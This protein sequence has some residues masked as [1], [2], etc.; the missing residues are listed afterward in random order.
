VCLAGCSLLA[1][2]VGGILL[3]FSFSTVRPEQIA[4]SYNTVSKSIKSDRVY[5]AGRFHLGLGR[6]FITYPQTIQTI[7][8]S[9]EPDADST[10][11]GV[12][13]KDGQSIDISCSFM[14]QLIPEKT[15]AIYEK[16]GANVESEP[17]K[18]IYIQQ[19]QSVIKLTTV[20]FNTLEF[21]Q[22][23]TDISD[24]IFSQLRT[25]MWEYFGNLRFFQLRTVSIPPQF[26][27]SVIKKLT[28]KQGV[29]K[30]VHDLTAQLVI[31]DVDRIIREG[32]AK[33]NRIMLTATAQ[34]TLIQQ[35]AEAKGRRMRIEAQA[36]AYDD[37][38]N[39]LNMTNDDLMY[40]KYLR[41]LRGRKNT[42]LLVDTPGSSV[43]LGSGASG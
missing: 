1:C 8:F 16:M 12:W 30:S 33:K 29:K 39:L 7:T 27:S 20:Q 17:W 9:N 2:F 4:I 41:T 42:R 5:T 34:G 19:A 35:Q 36:K 38:K 26:E 21:F 43:I 24:L 37:V 3:G 10:R 28:A 25:K 31:K 13:S 22:N 6:S 23:R 14:F 18:V 40:F 32:E 11:L 15:I